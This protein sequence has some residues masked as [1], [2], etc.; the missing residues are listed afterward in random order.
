MEKV[1]WTWGSLLPTA[2]D[3]LLLGSERLKWGG[4]M[5]RS[6]MQDNL[7]RAQPSSPSRH[8]GNWAE[9]WAPGSSTSP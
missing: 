3:A 6:E 1:P 5:E 2:A 4:R 8:P 9:P 7:S